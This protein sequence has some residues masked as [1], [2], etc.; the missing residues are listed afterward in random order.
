MSD[1]NPLG[2]MMHLKEIEREALA[3]RTAP[4]KSRPAIPNA[5]SGWIMRLLKRLS[6]SLKAMTAAGSAHVRRQ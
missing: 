5:A 3:L 6:I 1:V 4:M 2:P